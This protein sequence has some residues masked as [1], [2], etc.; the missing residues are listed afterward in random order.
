MGYSTIIAHQNCKRIKCPKTTSILYVIKSIYYDNLE[1]KSIFIYFNISVGRGKLIF[2]ISYF[3][4]GTYLLNC[5]QIILK[6]LLF[7]LVKLHYF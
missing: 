5:N 1:S 6:L 4:L 3:R 2:G 7:N